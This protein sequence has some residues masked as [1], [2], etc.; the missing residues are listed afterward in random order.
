MARKKGKDK[1]FDDTSTRFMPA[2][3]GGEP[4]GDNEKPRYFVASGKQ[5][6][7]RRGGLN[8]GEEIFPWYFIGGQA[9]IDDFVDKGCAVKKMGA[10]EE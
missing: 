4:S 9:T 3:C 8:E 10:V 7:S 6:T 5:M 1:D 2:P